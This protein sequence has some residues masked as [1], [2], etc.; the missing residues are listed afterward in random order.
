[1]LDNV[2]SAWQLPAQ[3]IFTPAPGGRSSESP[4]LDRWGKLSDTRRLGEGGTENQHFAPCGPLPRG[5]TEKGPAGSGWSEQPSAPRSQP[6]VYPRV[7]TQCPVVEKAIHC[8][9]STGQGQFCGTGI[10]WVSGCRA[11]AGL[12]PCCS[13][14][15]LPLACHVPRWDS[16]KSPRVDRGSR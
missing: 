10:P 4:P 16:G 13:L 12:G 6:T 15:V 3:S 8:S 14:P 7:V 5:P 9:A 11:R 2:L 1:M